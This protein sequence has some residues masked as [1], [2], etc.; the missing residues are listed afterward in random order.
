MN[1]KTTKPKMGPLGNPLGNPLGFFN[2]LKGKAKPEL[3]QNLKKAQNGQTVGPMD[4]NTAKYMDTKYPGTALK[5]NGPY[6]NDY[7]DRQKSKIANT[8][9]ATSWGSSADLEQSLR[10][11]EEK[12]LRSKGWREDF[13]NGPLKTAEDIEDAQYRKGGSIKKKSVIKKVKKK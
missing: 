5:L 6:S 13:N 8:Q 2:S 7:I 11:E 12:Q 9:G 1:K 10:N 3:K 4:S